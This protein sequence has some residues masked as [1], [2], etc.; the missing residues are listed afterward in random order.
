MLIIIL[1][2]ILVLR[3]IVLVLIVD[4]VLLSITRPMKYTYSFLPAMTVLFKMVNEYCFM[5][6]DYGWEIFFMEV[7]KRLSYSSLNDKIG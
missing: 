2:P 7:I 1:L 6:P 3:V 4:D 5:F